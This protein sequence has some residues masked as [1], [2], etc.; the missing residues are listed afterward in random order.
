MKCANEIVE[1]RSN[2]NAIEEANEK[3][4]L[5][6]RYLKSCSNSIRLCEE[7]IS[8]KIEEKAKVPGGN[9]VSISI[10]IWIYVDRF[11]NKMFKL[12]IEFPHAYANG[13][14]SWEAAGDFY[15]YKALVEY[16]SQFCFK[17]TISAGN[18]PLRCYGVGHRYYP[19]LNITT[20]PICE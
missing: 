9:N 13:E 17:T 6:A 18:S 8:K 1:I 16:L 2:V 3:A 20:A 19:T 10:P 15:S 11:G 4:R 14:S 7:Y 12:V 5:M